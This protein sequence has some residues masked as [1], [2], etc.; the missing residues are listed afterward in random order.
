MLLCASC[1]RIIS[2][3]APACRTCGE[4]LAGPPR[5]LE[6]VLGDGTRIPLGGTV[7]IGRAE[8]NDIRIEDPSISRRHARILVEWDGDE[9]RTLIEDAGSSYGT[10][11][12]GEPVESARP[13]RPGAQIRLGESE[14]RMIERD[15]EAPGAAAPKTVHMAAASTGVLQRADPASSSDELRPRARGGLAIKRLSERGR[16][17]A[18]IRDERE[19]SFIRISVDDADLFALLDGGRSLSELLGEAESR[20]GA[21][22]PSRLARLL[23]DL[24]D[25]GML[26]GVRGSDRG[27]SRG[28][29]TRMIRP[30]E[31]LAEDPDLV[32]E[33]LYERGGW[34]LFA[35]WTIGAFGILALAG[36]VSFALLIANRYGTP[37]VVADR[38]GIGALVFIVGRFALVGAH[39]FAHGLA[40]VAVGRTVHRAGVKLIAIFP[41]AFVDTSEAWFEPRRRRLVV[42]TA[43]PASDLAIGSVFALACLAL[44]VGTIRDITFQLALAG[45]VAAFFNLNPFIDR[46]GY[47]ILVDILDEPGLRRRS[48]AA[49]IARL[50]GREPPPDARG[51]LLRYAVAG[52]GWLVATMGLVAVMI[53]Q[54]YDQLTALVPEEAVLALVVALYALLLLPIVFTVVMPTIRRFRGATSLGRHVPR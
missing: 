28:L 34:R 14:L 3:D 5:V 32:F 40:M 15:E 37:F 46:D 4:P 35:D 42:A 36:L 22:G 6:L 54:Y 27:P 8:G 38:V 7:T 41:F 11:V 29:L 18:V 2:A 43:G 17:Y 20:F 12:D 16:R 9:R 21:E 24:G 19:G 31:R 50:S 39:E 1:H 10:R 23:A 48:Q 53:I 44:P 45:Y 25:R 33:E 49:L 47:H 30:R 26:E 51:V 52:L 13:L